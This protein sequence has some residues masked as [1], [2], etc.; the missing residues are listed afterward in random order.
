MSEFVHEE[1]YRHPDVDFKSTSE[2][3]SILLPKLFAE[4]E[5]TCE[6]KA[7]FLFCRNVI[8]NFIYREVLNLRTPISLEFKY[9]KSSEE[10]V[11]TQKEELMIRLAVTYILHSF[12][13]R[14]LNRCLAEFFSLKKKDDYLC[15]R[16][17]SVARKSPN[18]PERKKFL[19][20]ENDISNEI[21]HVASRM[22]L[23]Y[24]SP[25]TGTKYTWTAPEY[26]YKSPGCFDVTIRIDT[27][28]DKEINDYSEY[29]RYLLTKERNT[30]GDF[31][32]TALWRN[33]MHFRFSKDQPL[34][35][36]PANNIQLILF[37]LSIG[38]DD[39]V[40]NR[41]ISLRN[42]IYD[43]EALMK[44]PPLTEREKI[45]LLGYLKDSQERLRC[46]RNEEFVSNKNDIV[47]RVIVNIT[48]DLIKANLLPVT[49]LT[50]EEIELTGLSEELLDQ[51]YDK[52]INGK[53][54]F[55]RTISTE[56]Y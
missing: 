37:C 54:I 50:E 55:K 42:K 3:A 10:R 47:R 28:R 11:N 38:M 35:S 23:T 36:F 31:T 51:A 52:D 12:H 26:S 39:C 33:A 4:G 7:L 13:N 34:E 44:Q 18:Y 21:F 43:N 22:S 27:V 14:R 49:I 56:N 48:M 16:I 40:F 24:I 6:E 9:N 25:N 17:Q 46:A 20:L 45:V 53:M 41:L 19:E 32:S 15:S 8:E 1:Y 5:Y 29:I 2:M 30:I